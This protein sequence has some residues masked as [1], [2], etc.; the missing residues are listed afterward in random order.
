MTHSTDIDFPVSQTWARHYAGEPP[1]RE[2]P[3]LYPVERTDDLDYRMQADLMHG[4]VQQVRDLQADVAALTLQV[5]SLSEWR[6]NVL[7]RTEE[8]A[9]QPAPVKPAPPA[10]TD[11]TWL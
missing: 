11:D 1:L 10:K 9:K 3:P 7:K 8:R 6:A 5:K 2:V 4:L